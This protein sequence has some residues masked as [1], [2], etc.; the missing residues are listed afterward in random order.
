MHS[1]IHEYKRESVKDGNGGFIHRSRYLGSVCRNDGKG[2][3]P[4]C[5][6][7]GRQTLAVVKEHNDRTGA[8]LFPAN[9][10]HVQK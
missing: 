4:L 1:Y 5:G 7:R 6:E 2:N 10:R 3:R 8:V 9:S